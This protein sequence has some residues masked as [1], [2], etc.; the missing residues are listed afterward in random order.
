[1]RMWMIPPGML[2]DKHLLGE[3]LECHMVAG[4][5]LKGREESIKGLCRN[6]LLEPQHLES[7]HAELVAEMQA[8]GMRHASSLPALPPEVP[9]GDVDVQE[10]YHQLLQ[11]CVSCKARID[12]AQRRKET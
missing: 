1:M 11:R 4:S 7:R 9:R 6:D 12:E 10:S 5:L 3:H 2:C 8:R